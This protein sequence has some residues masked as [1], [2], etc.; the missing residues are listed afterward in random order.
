MQK[1]YSTPTVVTA[2][3]VVRETMGNAAIVVEDGILRSPTSNVGF[4][5]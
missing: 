4:G 3:S 5:L 2:G 1:T